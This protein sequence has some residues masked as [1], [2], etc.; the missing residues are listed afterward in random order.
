MN[1][2]K[3]TEISVHVPSCWIESVS[4]ILRQVGA[5]GVVIEDPALMN[6][7]FEEDTEESP[8]IVSPDT[9]TAVVKAYF[10]QEMQNRLVEKIRCYLNEAGI[11][12]ASIEIKEVIEQDWLEAW[13]AY[14]KPVNIGKHLVVRPIWEEYNAGENEIVI[15]LNPGMAFG[16]GTHATTVLCLEI[17]EE[18][19][20]PGDKVLDI[21]TGSGILAVASTFLGATR[22]TAVDSDQAALSVAHENIQNNRVESLVT[23][24]E[25]DLL[26]NIEGDADVVVANI[27]TPVIKELAPDISR[28]LKPGGYF[29]AS[30]ITSGRVP[31]VRSVMEDLGYCIENIYDKDQWVALKIKTGYLAENT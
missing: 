31:E 8:E 4:Y 14:Y 3:W 26:Q 28:V 2:N 17:L 15:N 13:K 6:R 16:N 29:I 22:V 25:G 12:Q 1:S 7:L 24:Q 10:P 11:C 9:G 30:G 23:V 20:K 19:I 18:I 21:G 5:G 27:L